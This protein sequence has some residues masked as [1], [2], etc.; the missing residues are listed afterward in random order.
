[1]LDAYCE[2]RP[3]RGLEAL[4]ACVWE[5]QP[6]EDRAQR[7][8]PDACVDLIWLAERE[9]VIAG[10]D[11]GPR[12]VELPAHA[13]S[14]GIRLRPGAAGAVLG[15]PAYELCDLQLPLGVA[16]SLAAVLRRR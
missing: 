16:S 13:R 1:V 14:S 11:T 12:N 6:A 7:V 3:P 9:L 4:V 8:V 10:A 5:H 2:H 15:L